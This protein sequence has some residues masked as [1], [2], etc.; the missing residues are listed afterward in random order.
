MTDSVGVVP[1]CIR[2]SS[3]WEVRI[4]FFDFVPRKYME[5]FG[6]VPFQHP[7]ELRIVCLFALGALKTLTARL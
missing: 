6:E 7:L 2:Y 5:Y 1:T 3:V 4:Y